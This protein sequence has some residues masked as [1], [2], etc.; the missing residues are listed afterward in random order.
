M[1]REKVKAKTETVLILC[2]SVLIPL[3]LVGYGV[4]TRRYESL[5]KEVI[6]LEDK[7]MKL[8]EENKTLIANISM[9]S[10]ANRIER[11]AEQQLGMHKAESD[12]IVR[13]EMKSAAK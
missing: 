12:E 13:V 11:I 5:K 1:N 2:C 6:A 7:Q 10:N 8:V 9:L 3:L 4:Q